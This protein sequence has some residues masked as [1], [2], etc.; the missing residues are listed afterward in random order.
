MT[1]PLTVAIVNCL[2]VE[3]SGRP[4]AIPITTIERTV[5]VKKEDIKTIQNQQVFI[6][7][8]HDVPLLDLH[9]IFGF[10]V[11]ER[12]KYEVIIIENGNDEV[13]LIVDKVITQQQILIKSLDKMVKGIKGIGG[14]T[15]LGDGSVSLIV[16]VA[17]L[18]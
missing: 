12:D 11:V 10:E 9:K 1:L 6:L 13:G 5:Q 14:A 18:F 4:Y 7:R 2:M 3:V 17:T 8:D 15:I 16:D